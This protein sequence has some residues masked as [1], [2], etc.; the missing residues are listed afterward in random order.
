M[1][2]PGFEYPWSRFQSFSFGEAAGE[3]TANCST[4]RGRTAAIS[5]LYVCIYIYIY[6]YMY[7]RSESFC[8]M[9]R[10]TDSETVKAVNLE[11]SASP[12]VRNRFWGLP[13]LPVCNC[14]QHFATEVM[15]ITLISTVFIFISFV[16]TGVA[17][18]YAP[19]WWGWK[20][21]PW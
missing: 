2:M 12:L 19:G 14:V 4:S 8:L 16:C 15:M 13:G 9:Q 5:Q 17:L 6:I 3:K 18:D 10:E 11:I 1:F 21:V 7:L 20:Y